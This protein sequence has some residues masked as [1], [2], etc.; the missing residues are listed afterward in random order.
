MLGL[1]ALERT[2]KAIACELKLGG[3]KVGVLLAAVVSLSGCQSTPP[4]WKS[5]R[6]IPI[7]AIIGEWGGFS[8]EHG[9]YLM[10]LEPGGSGLF[11]YMPYGEEPTLLRVSHWQCKETQL[12]VGLAPIAQN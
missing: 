6:V 9:F 1:Q 2:M 4:A 10:R 8:E 12:S 3:M 11:G 5:A 7:E